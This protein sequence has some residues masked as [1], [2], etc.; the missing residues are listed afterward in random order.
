MS[1]QSTAKISSKGQITLPKP[2]Q[3]VLGGDIVRIV[4]EGDVVRLE[5]V[6]DL[7]GSLKRYAVDGIG[8]SE[9]RE[10]AWTEVVHDRH[11]RD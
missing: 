11:S 10:V 7:A 5:P 2:V 3:A 8:N 6:H 1:F 4:V 9:A